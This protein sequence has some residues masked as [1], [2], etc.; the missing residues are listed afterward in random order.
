MIGAV[1]T[2]FFGCLHSYFALERHAAQTEK[3]TSVTIHDHVDLGEVAC[4]VR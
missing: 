4:Q 1:M 3:P 2:L